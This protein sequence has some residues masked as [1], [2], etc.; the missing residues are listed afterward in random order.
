MCE[1]LHAEV[2]NIGSPRLSS[3][4]AEICE[5]F[6]HKFNCMCSCVLC[7]LVAGGCW[8]GGGGAIRVVAAGLVTCSDGEDPNLLRLFQFAQTIVPFAMMLNRDCVAVHDY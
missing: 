2:C 8:G 6:N 5:G 7:C 3:L 1:S 4:C